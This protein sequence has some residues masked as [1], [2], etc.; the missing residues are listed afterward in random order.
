MKENF[1]LS[2]LAL[3][4]MACLCILAAVVALF[5]CQ[6]A[7]PLDPPRPFIGE[8]AGE[9]ETEGITFL[10]TLSIREDGTY[11]ATTQHGADT[12]TRERGKWDATE[13]IFRTFSQVCEE[14]KPLLLIA[15]SEDWESVPIN[16]EAGA[17]TIH[18]AGAGALHS[19]TLRR[20]G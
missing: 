5:G 9:Y 8:W 13:T 15:C 20:V 2:A 6:H 4:L 17:W 12:L 11:R 18:L 19:V 7:E 1:D 14:G 10:L 16:I 3:F